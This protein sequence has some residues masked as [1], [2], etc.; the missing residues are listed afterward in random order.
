VLQHL[1][2]TTLSMFRSD[3]GTHSSA[4]FILEFFKSIGKTKFSDG[5]NLPSMEVCDRLRAVLYRKGNIVIAILSFD[6]E[7]RKSIKRSMHFSSSGIIP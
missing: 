3:I 5:M 7:S 2:R 4:H 1:K 6:D